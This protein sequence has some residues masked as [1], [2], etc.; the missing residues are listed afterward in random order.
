MKGGTVLDLP[1]CALLKVLKTG[2]ANSPA[3]S[4]ELGV[5]SKMNEVELGWS[6]SRSRSWIL[7]GVGS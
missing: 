1:C 4:T 7:A 5:M 6:R 2:I 3:L